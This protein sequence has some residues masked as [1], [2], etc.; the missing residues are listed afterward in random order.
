M[1]NI[2][3]LSDADIIP[4]SYQMRLMAWR[5]EFTRGYF[6]IGDIANEI[7]VLNI[8]NKMQIEQAQIYSAVGRFCGKSGR[9]I[10]DYAEIAAFFPVAIRE[11]Y[12]MLPF[13]HFRFAKSRG[14][15]WEDVLEYS[16]LHPDAPESKLAFEFDVSAD[17]PIMFTN[18]DLSPESVAASLNSSVAARPQPSVAPIVAADLS[19]IYVLANLIS[20]AESMLSWEMHSDT[21][22]KLKNSLSGLKDVLKDLSSK[23]PSLKFDYT[24]YRSE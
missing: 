6:E 17:R 14:S 15:K 8:Q 10:R 21:R 22:L 12:D 7:S 11:R 5:D 1:Q 9:T 18:A 23:E 13:S 3:T 4:E 16:M 24:D 2:P 19:G 20:Q